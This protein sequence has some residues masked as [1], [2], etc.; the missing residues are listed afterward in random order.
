MLVLVVVATV[1]VTHFAVMNPVVIGIFHDDGIYTV[2]AKSLA[3]GAGYRLVSL[4]S[5]PVQLK[6]P[7]LY[8]SMLGVLWW[9]LPSFPENVALFKFNVIPSS[10]HNAIADRC[11]HIR[12]LDRACPLVFS[13][14]KL[15]VSDALF[16]ALTV[17]AVAFQRVRGTAG[18]IALATVAAAAYLT[19]TLG[20]ALSGAFVIWFILHRSYRKPAHLPRCN[21]CSDFT[22]VV[23]A[24]CPAQRRCGQH[25]AG[26]LRR[27]QAGESRL[28]GRLVRLV[29]GRRDRLD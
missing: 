28:Y 5:S 18:T 8:S 9:L 10:R 1:L 7:A 16:F 26:V 29:Q 2:L 23:L 11:R 20:I 4:P 14:T 13:L 19:R 15:P 27:I 6:Y 22:V 25:N 3:D 24:A 21:G 17:G 12:S